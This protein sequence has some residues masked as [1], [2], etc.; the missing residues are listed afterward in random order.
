MLCSL[1]TALGFSLGAAVSPG[2][3]SFSVLAPAL[4]P[5]PP[6]PRQ[7]GTLFSPCTPSFEIRLRVLTSKSTTHTLTHTHIHAPNHTHSLSHTQSISRCVHAWIHKR[8]QAW[9]QQ[10]P[11]TTWPSPLAPPFLYKY[12]HSLP[13]MKFT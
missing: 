9:H 8:A 4:H 10:D 11:T 5:S 13:T 7:K 6:A 2:S 12:I 3:L 1:A